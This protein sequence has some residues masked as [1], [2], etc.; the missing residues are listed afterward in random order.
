MNWRNN[1]FSCLNFPVSSHFLLNLSSFLYRNT[2]L[3]SYLINPIRKISDQEKSDNYMQKFLQRALKSTLST[4]S[5][6]VWSWIIYI[7]YWLQMTWISELTGHT[8]W[9]FLKN[10]TDFAQLGANLERILKYSNIYIEWKTF[11]Q[12]CVKFEQVLP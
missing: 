7:Y 10:F 6:D 9:S 3:I 11:I 12:G 8:E 5:A 1:K 2:L 4:R